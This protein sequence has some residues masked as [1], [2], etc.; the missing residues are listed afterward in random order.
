EV[1]IGL[2][3][4]DQR[5]P[6][7]GVPADKCP[8]YRQLRIPKAVTVSG[9]TAIRHSAGRDLHP[10]KPVVAKLEI[11]IEPQPVTEPGT[12]LSIVNLCC[13]RRAVVVL[14]AKTVIARER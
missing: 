1:G 7:R 3:T 8:A 2:F 4:K 9:E 10:A 13:L 14:V 5:G 11:C 6:V 12:M